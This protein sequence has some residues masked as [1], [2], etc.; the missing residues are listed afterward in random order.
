MQNIKRIILQYLIFAQK[1]FNF[2]L[3]KTR[4]ERMSTFLSQIRKKTSSNKDLKLLPE[5]W[6]AW[7]VIKPIQIY[8]IKYKLY[9]KRLAQKF[10]SMCLI[11]NKAK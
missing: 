8:I 11:M 3:G 4:E 2:F 1:K 9:K 7:S 5:I 10:P 6:K